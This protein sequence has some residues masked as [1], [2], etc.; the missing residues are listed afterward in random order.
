M[1]SVVIKIQPDFIEQSYNDLI[2]MVHYVAATLDNLTSVVEY[3]LDQQNEEAM[4][5]VVS[6]ANAWCKRTMSRNAREWESQ[7]Y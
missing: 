5:I 6:N 2:P 4:R 1:N 7:A 3:V